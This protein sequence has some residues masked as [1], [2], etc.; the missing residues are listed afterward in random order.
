VNRG[1]ANPGSGLRLAS[2]ALLAAGALGLL[3]CGDSSSTAAATD[4]GGWAGVQQLSG[5]ASLLEQLAAGPAAHAHS[6]I[7]WVSLTQYAENQAPLQVAYTERV[8]V[9]GQGSYALQPLQVLSPV[10]PDPASFLVLQEAHAGYHFQYR[11][12]QIR[13]LGLMVQNYTANTTEASPTVVAGRQCL[14][15]AVVPNDGTGFRYQLLVDLL[16]GLVLGE[17]VRDDLGRLVQQSLYL[18]YVD[19]EPSSFTPHVPLAP[20]EV[21]DLGGDLAAQV[22]YPPELP[23]YVPQGFQLTELARVVDPEQQSWLRATYTDGV[24]PLFLLL[25]APVNPG[26]GSTAIWL[27]PAAI[28]GGDEVTAGRLV[29]V[30][31]GRAMAIEGLF[32]QRHRSVVGFLD[33]LELQVMLESTTP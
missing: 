15:I 7:R 11:N 30:R 19:G 1:V 29:G 32:E 4:L 14:S 31:V 13:D 28:G 5:Q 18:E 17:E 2:R 16:N 6:G 26:P 3:G 23:S 27:D 10:E 8:L 20:A 12:F 25:R 9:D 21:Y 24:E 33:A 22:G